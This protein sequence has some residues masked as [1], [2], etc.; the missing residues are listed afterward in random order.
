MGMSQHNPPSRFL[1]DIPPELVA[2]HEPVRTEA[3]AVE[4]GPQRFRQA[5]DDR[6]PVPDEAAFSA[7]EKVRHPRFGEGIVVSCNVVS[8][9]QE[10]TVAFKGEAGIKKL[11]LSF[12]P[13][14]KV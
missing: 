5:R 7:G 1:K 4:R 2:Q 9:D 12:A 10:V 8:D 14:E 11:M 6:P 13:L 3:D